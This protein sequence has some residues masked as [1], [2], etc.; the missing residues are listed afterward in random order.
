MKKEKI[1]SPQHQLY[2]NYL[3]AEF[4]FKLEEKDKWRGY[5]MRAKAFAAKIT[6][7]I[8]VDAATRRVRCGSTL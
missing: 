8:C 1:D 7:Y 6:K 3:Y 2:I 4:Y 5:L